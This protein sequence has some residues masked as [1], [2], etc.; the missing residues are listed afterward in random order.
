MTNSRND[1][2]LNRYI[3]SVLRLKGEGKAAWQG[4]GIEFAV[5]SEGSKIPGFRQVSLHLRPGRSY[6]PW[7][8]VRHTF[9]GSQFQEKVFR[10]R[11]KRHGKL[12]LNFH[13]DFVAETPGRGSW[14][15]YL[16]VRSPFAHF[17][18]LSE[19]DEVASPGFLRRARQLEELQHCLCGEESQ[20]VVWL[21]GVPGL[22]KT[23]LIRHLIRW[24][25]EDY[26]GRMTPVYVDV[27]QEKIQRRWQLLRSIGEEYSRQ[28]GEKLSLQEADFRFDY[29]YSN[30]AAVRTLLAKLPC[31]VILDGFYSNPAFLKPRQHQDSNLL[32]AIFELSVLSC[33]EN[34]LNLIVADVVSFKERLDCLNET[35]AQWLR[36]KIGPKVANVS[37]P[38]FTKDE[39]EIGQLLR[40]NFAEG[41]AVHS[42]SSVLLGNLYSEVGGHPQI[43]CRCFHYSKQLYRLGAGCPEFNI[44]QACKGARSLV[45]KYK[46]LGLLTEELLT[47]FARVRGVKGWWLPPKMRLTDK[48]VKLLVRLGLIRERR[49]G[50]VSEYQVVPVFAE[51]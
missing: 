48:Q 41:Y 28:T 21:H 46:R 9:E 14:N 20:P 36:K 26:T 44:E 3:L 29:V 42:L 24:L 22:G 27:S 4:G 32:D 25:K 5:I 50:P 8:K 30:A 13:V 35:N 51:R 40:S 23:V 37:L 45:A 33:S 38:L 11:A 18:G 34:S 12:R 49:R 6:E 19:D 7:G 39:D 2:S 10:I 47:C 43:L 1:S 31:L 17:E 15:P 16:E